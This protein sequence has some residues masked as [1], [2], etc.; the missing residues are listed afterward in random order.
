VYSLK[1]GNLTKTLAV[2]VLK[3]ILLIG[4]W[5]IWYRIYAWLN[6]R[7]ALIGTSWNPP[8]IY[9]P[10]AVYPYTFGGLLLPFLPFFWNWRGDRFAKLLTIYV[11]AN[12]I[13]F[14]IYWLYPVYMNRITYDSPAF[15]DSLMRLITS[16][17]NPANCFPSGHCLF[18][19]LGFL[20]VW[21]GGAG[22]ITTWATGVLAV[23]VCVTTVLVG[24]HYWMDIPAGIATGVFAFMI[25]SY[26]GQFLKLDSRLGQSDAIMSNS[27]SSTDSKGEDT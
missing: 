18:A 6:A 25:I 2:V 22:R 24:Q 21:K 5:I 20:G 3:L 1:S 12:T 11:I 8:D 15:A 10:L 19:T 27:Y 4:F 14:T 17:D 7:G 13:A 23:V 16:V 9:V 26:S